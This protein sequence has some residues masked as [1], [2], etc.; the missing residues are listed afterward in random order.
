MGLFYLITLIT[1][2]N[3]FTVVDSNKMCYRGGLNGVTNEVSP[4]CEEPVVPQSYVAGIFTVY[5]YETFL[6]ALG[7]AVA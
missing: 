1:F 5:I 3:I 7:F 2:G 6:Q 4:H